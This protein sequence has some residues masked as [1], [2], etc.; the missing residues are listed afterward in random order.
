MSVRSASR[1][2]NASKLSAS[3]NSSKSSN[4][5]RASAASRSSKKSQSKNIVIVFDKRTNE[6]RQVLLP[7]NEK[8]F[9]MNIQKV[10]RRP[11]E[12][13]QLENENGNEITDFRDVTPGI[14][15][16][17]VFQQ[18][19][20]KKEAT[21]EAESMTVYQANPLK[22]VQP[23]EAYSD[24][25][26]L[27]K[28]FGGNIRGQSPDKSSRMSSRT[29]SPDIS[30]QASSARRRPQNR[31]DNSSQNLSVNESDNFDQDEFLDESSEASSSMENDGQYRQKDEIVGDHISLDLIHSCIQDENRSDIVNA[32]SKLIDESKEM[33]NTVFICENEQK[34]W[35]LKEMKKILTEQGLNPDIKNIISYH[36]LVQ[37]ANDL[38][39]N[40]RLANPIVSSYIFHS[41]I[42]G[43]SK[44]GKSTFLGILANQILID[45]VA[46]DNW[47]KTFVFVADI[48][49]IMMGFQDIQG[50]YNTFIHHIFSLLMAQLPSMVKYIPKI[51]QAFLS[52]TQLTRMETLPLPKRL[53]QSLEHK[54]LSTELQEIGLSLASIWFDPTSLSQWI[55]SLV[56]LPTILARA[57][58]FHDIIYILDHFEACS[59]QLDASYPFED[60]QPIMFVNEYW[61]YAINNHAYIVSCA[62]E[63]SLMNSLAM[64]DETSIDLLSDIEFISLFDIY[65]DFEYSDKELTMTFE[66]TSSPALKLTATSCGGVPIYVNQ[67]IKVNQRMDDLEG[68][69]EKT[70]EYEEI[71][72][73]VLSEAEKLLFL[74]IQREQGDP[75][76]S[77]EDQ[78]FGVYDIH[79]H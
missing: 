25:P 50:F 14:K 38:I 55:T 71:F 24:T 26:A 60:S 78:R 17:V 30:S 48:D 45:L 69:E 15:L 66:D 34:V 46:T 7:S 76:D 4:A 56:M 1:A 36:A 32:Y 22:K 49:K 6:K 47:K 20:R 18:K 10:F 79:R 31:G 68:V 5:S 44:S 53:T 8:S 64:Y 42:I 2:S 52:I 61:K 75:N 57:F 28:L 72:C 51:E 73:Q 37:K 39:Q 74:L 67:W 58:G 3:S 77:I 54:R 29:K 13:F 62:D 59:V 41:S 11:N 43:P 63:T 35:F 9:R 33:L 27:K 70:S 65:E 21:S 40:H 12:K 16:Y 19:P 23:N